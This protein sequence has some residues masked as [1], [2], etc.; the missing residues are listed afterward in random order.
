MTGEVSLK[1]CCA[2]LYA[3]DWAKL[4]LGD[5]LHPGGVKL[6]ER[7]GELLGLGPGDRVLDMAAG[8]GT[9]AVHLALRF[10]CD[11]LGVEYGAAN[12]AA[13]GGEARLA[14]L[15]EH[16]WFARG[17]A[18]R[19][20]CGDAQFDAVI[21]ECAFCTFTDKAAAATELGRVLRPGGVVGLGD[22]V[23]RRPLPRG[24]DDLL[25]WVACVAG[26]CTAEEYVG[27]L[28]EAG[29]AGVA[30]EDHD[31]ALADLVRQARLRLLGATVAV[32]LEAMELPAASL[33]IAKE[34]ARGA[35]RAVLDGTLG[36]ALIT[37]RKPR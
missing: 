35:E 6:T 24:L 10:G 13:A 32:R 9:S 14:G 30:V 21:C 17:D 23:R 5:S 31:Q 15:S 37:A 3:S 8:R 27:Q 20:P 22:L 19:L 34:M 1:S 2:D 11:V 26:V 33:A 7:L 12:A 25:A 28:R 18:E 4:L 29:L 36:Y 16:A